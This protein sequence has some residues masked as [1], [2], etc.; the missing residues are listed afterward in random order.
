MDEVEVFAAASGIL[1]DFHLVLVQIA[2][3]NADGILVVDNGCLGG[4][5]IIL[6][7]KLRT[8]PVY[9]AYVDLRDIIVGDVLADALYHASCRTVGERQAEHVAIR[10]AVFLMGTANALG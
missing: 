4:D 10:H 2:C 5:N 9:V 7:Q 6:K 3:H 1:R 8:K